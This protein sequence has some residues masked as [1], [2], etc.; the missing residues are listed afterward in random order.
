M[1]YDITKTMYKKILKSCIL[2]PESSHGFTLVEL[3]AVVFVFIAV[4]SILLGI[5]V[6]V[7]RGNN[8][9]NAIN[10]VQSNGDYAMGQMTKS[11][12][13]ATTLL[14]PLDCGT[15]DS[16][17]A[18]SSVALEFPDGTTTTY[19][20]LDDNGA[21]SITSNSAALVDTNSVAIASCTFSCGYDSASDYP[22]IGIDFSLQSKVSSGS[23]VDLTA[24]AS[25]VHFQTSVVIRNL[26][27]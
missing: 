24:S 11:I 13:N 10:I 26:I 2:N 23:I 25:A 14:G 12:R 18:T 19:S 6:S 15:V 16:P 8:K 22:I 5:V 4:G 7:L 3:L 17:T 20:C 21:P 27:R 9:T 1:I